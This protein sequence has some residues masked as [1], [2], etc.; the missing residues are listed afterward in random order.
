M[1]VEQVIKSQLIAS[2]ELR[3]TITLFYTNN[4]LY[5]KHV[6]FFKKFGL[7]NQQYNVL[8]IL[9]GQYPSPASISLIKDRML[10]KMSDTSR[11]VDRLIKQQLIIR[12]TN[13]NDK[14]SVDVKI[15]EQ[16]LKLML[17]ID[18]EIPMVEKHI[19]KLT[20]TEINQ[21]CDL[22]DKLRG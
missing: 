21:L 5:E 15:T 10:D 20:D 17:E 13:A 22:L 3:A 19:K 12:Q 7:T 6:K 4:W 2:N 8:R 11:L 1:K 14:R 16:G 9:R 18:A